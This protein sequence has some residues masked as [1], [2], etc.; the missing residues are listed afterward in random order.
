MCEGASG[1]AV[2]TEKA[3]RS[4]WWWLRC[5][6]SALEELGE[7][8]EGRKAELVELLVAAHAG[9]A[10]QEA[11]DGEGEGEGEEDGEEESPGDMEDRNLLEESV[12]NTRLILKRQK[13]GGAHDLLYAK[14]FSCGICKKAAK[15][16]CKPCM[17]RVC[18]EPAC[19]TAHMCHGKGMKPTGKIQFVVKERKSNPNMAREKSAPPRRRVSVTVGGGRI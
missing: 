12:S 14:P 9:A 18:F 4:R 13:A 8:T 5:A 3:E 19:I 16:A 2:A 7:D 15:Y 10:A 11:D 6:R 17:V 1:A